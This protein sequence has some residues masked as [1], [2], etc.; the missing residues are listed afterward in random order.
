MLCGSAGVRGPQPPLP[1]PPALPIGMPTPP[2]L[3]LNCF[4]GLL[5]AAWA[6]SARTVYVGLSA[7]QLTGPAFPPAWLAANASSDV[8]YLLLSGN[9]EMGGL[10]PPGLGWSSLREL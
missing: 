9:R 5:P 7:N 8:P 1:N 6:S 2:Q 10:L 4:A 3:D